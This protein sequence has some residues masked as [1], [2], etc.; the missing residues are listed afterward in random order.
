LT[1]ELLQALEDE[2]GGCDFSDESQRAFLERLDACD[3]QAAPGNGKTTLLVAK[4]ALLSRTWCDRHRGVCVVSHTNAARAEVQRRL[5]AHP[6]ACAFLSYPH[7]IGTVTAFIDQFISLPYLRGLGWP[8]RRIDDEALGSAAKTLIHN[9][10]TLNASWRRS[11]FQVEG[12]VANLTLADDFA[13]G[14]SGLPDRLAVR[15]AHRQPGP[16]T[17]SGAELENIKA[18]LVRRGI[19]RY[20]DMHVLARRALAECPHLAARLRAR[21]PLVIL[22]EAQDTSGELLQLLNLVFEGDGTLQCLGDQNQTLYEDAAVP[23]D[24][25]WQPAADSLPL[26]TTRRF[27]PGI[28]EFASRLTARRAQTIVAADNRPAQRLLLTFDR[29]SIVD[30]IPRYAEW[31]SEHLA[32]RLTTADVRAV[33]SRHNLYRDARGD[34]PKS[35]VDYHPAYRSGEGRGAVSSTLCGAM[36]KV[37]AGHAAGRHPRESHIAIGAA[38]ADYLDHR[39]FRLDGERVRASN[40]WSSLA[41][42]SPDQPVRARQLVIEYVIR[43]RAADEAGRW[44]GFCDALLAAFPR[45]GLGPHGEYCAFSAEG[46]VGDAQEVRSTPYARIAGVNVRLGS[47]HS[48]K[49]IT[50]DA[51]MMVET[52]VYRGPAR[53][54]RTMDL[55]SVL[56]HAFGLEA[57]DFTQNEAALSAATN[58]F[59]AVTR[60]RDLL[61]LAVRDDAVGDDLRAAAADQG[62]QVVRLRD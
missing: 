51:V 5:G 33:A 29:P 55:A 15:A 22:D 6:S 57:R 2:L 30:V 41:A 58:V 40:I 26:D 47:V 10:P 12:W 1:P 20:A 43:G 3:V 23:A 18:A 39:G 31:V 16:T 14:A 48:V 25:Y 37:A 11:A 13:P 19:Y 62:W 35:L 38:L 28:A 46:A 4:L 21:F 27:G 56:P 9:M 59:V 17:A 7:F 60:P 50:A 45:E 36:R 24:Q 61:A 42:I 32:D 44:I 52:E 49:G 34:W 54:Q 53:E 8:M